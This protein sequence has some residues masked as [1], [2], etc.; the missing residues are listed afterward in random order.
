[1]PLKGIREGERKELIRTKT[2]LIK[3]YPLSLIPELKLLAI[4]LV[5]LVTRRDTCPG[6]K[7]ALSMQ[8]RPGITPKRLKLK[9]TL[10]LQ[11]AMWPKLYGLIKSKTP[12]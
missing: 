2:V 7:G 11:I 10:L 9:K 1:M 12:L 4:L 6:I 8:I 5:I 3:L